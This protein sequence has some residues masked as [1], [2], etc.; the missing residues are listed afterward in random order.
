MKWE[1][2]THTQILYKNK[3][4]QIYHQL[5]TDRYKNNIS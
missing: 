1:N 4:K 3:T 5:T 2:F